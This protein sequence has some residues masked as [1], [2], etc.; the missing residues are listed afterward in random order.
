MAQATSIDGL[1]DRR[2]TLEQPAE[3]YRVAVDI[4]VGSY[5][6]KAGEKALGTGVGGAM[7]SPGLPHAGVDHRRRNRQ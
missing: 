7:A 6:L 3:G 1:L 5:Y 4:T 2:V